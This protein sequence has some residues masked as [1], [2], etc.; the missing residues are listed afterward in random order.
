MVGRETSQYLI[1]AARR[2][3]V[4]AADRLR[5]CREPAVRAR[6]GT[7][8]RSGGADGAR[9]QPRRVIAQ[10][11]TESVLLSVCGAALGPGDRAIGACRPSRPACRRR[12]QRYILGWKDIALDGRT[13]LF[14]FAAAVLSGILAGL[15]P[16][17]QCSRP[18]LD[19]CAEGRRTR[20]HRPGAAAIALRNIL[21]GAEIALAVVLL[22]G[23]GLMVRGFGTAGSTAPTLEPETLLTLRLALTDNKY[24]EPHQRAAFY[25]DVLARVAAIPGVRSAAAASA[26]PY[27]DHSSGREFTIEGRPAEP[28]NPRTAMYQAASADFFETLHVPLRAGRLLA[29]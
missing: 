21:V 11:V 25:R 24:H 14:T 16:A 17:W 20:R 10:L 28:G 3:A 6:Y 12:S 26:M 23:A 5:E 2:G 27:S 22:V 7:A 18:N 29:E 15:A 1:D 8:A 9:R 13:L 19:R 4:R